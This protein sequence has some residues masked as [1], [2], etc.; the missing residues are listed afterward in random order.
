MSIAKSA[1][2]LF[3]LDW[4][5][6]VDG[7]E[8]KTLASITLIIDDTPIWPIR[9]EEADDFEWF[10]DELLSHLTECW[11][12]LILRQNYPIPVQPERPSFLIAEASKRWSGLSDAT[13][14]NEQ[15]A[16]AAFEDVHNLA[17]AFGG[18]TGLLPLW[19]MR[20]QDT[21]IVDT[22]ELQFRLPIQEVINALVS[23][24]DTIAA[25]LKKVDQQKWSKLLLAWDRRDQGDAALMLALTIGRD[26]SSAA[27]LIAEK[28]L[29]APK[30][31]G[32]AVN[33][34]DELRIAAR[35]A[36]PMPLN[37]IKS[38]IKEVRKCRLRN[39][40]KLQEIVA[41]ATQ[42]IETNGLIDARPYIQGNAL[43]IWLRRNLNLSA[44][45]TVD[46]IQILE[47]QFNIDVRVIDF[48]I[49][50]LDAIAVWGSKHGPGVLLNQ[51]SKRIHKPANI[52]RN[53]ALRVTAA[54]ELCHLLLDSRHTL[55]AVDILG[56]RM[57]LRIEQRAKAFAAE[58]LLPSK[59]AGEVW[60][61]KGYP[62]DLE[63]LQQIIKGLCHRFNVTKSV[64]AWQLQHGASEANWDELDRALSQLVPHR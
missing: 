48:G 21:M 38:V 16:V 8:C 58:F 50:S 34:N 31:F 24:G 43:A 4:K 23:A 13:I 10:A 41:A 53:G 3:K 1:R 35:M 55:S 64:A 45:R 37:Q 11:K 52:W 63:T 28:I 33:D 51:T 30:S 2:I 61:N 18:I 7:I 15:R 6:T 27:I 56:G 46:P 44:N 5:D 19:F 9:G 20:D 39:A 42:F 32:E 49:Q 25:R 60:R 36:G 47:R 29:E 12:P 22:Q 59:E 26:Q 40:P 57:S 14:E 54:H 62:L 17:N